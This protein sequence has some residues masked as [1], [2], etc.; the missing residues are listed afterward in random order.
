[1]TN[2]D[3]LK[4]ADEIYPQAV[5]IRRYLHENP[6]IGNKE[7]LA[8][9]YIK[10]FLADCGIEVFS[11]L[12]TG[13]VGVLSCGEG[14][15]V[16]L[17]ADID[18]LP[19]KEETALPYSSKN[20]GFMH[21]CGHDLHTAALLAAA[22]VLSQHKD[23][24]HGT[25][26]FIFQ[27]DEEGFGGA[28]R[29]LAAGAF[30]NPD[31]S[32]VFGI[33]IRPEIQSGTVAVRYGKSYAASDIFT[34]TVKGKSAHG[35]EPQNGKN[36]LIAA[37]NICK[38]LENIIAE[39]LGE[40][41]DA[42]LSICTFESGTACNIIPDKATVTG[43]IRTFGKTAR[44]AVKE[45]LKKR[46]ENAAR[47]NGCEADIHIRESYPGVVN[48]NEQTDFVLAC[49]NELFGKENTLV[50]SHP[51]LT[52]EDFG[53]YLDEADGCFYHIGAGSEYPLHNGKM[54]PDEH[55][56]KAAVAMHIKTVFEALKA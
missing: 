51:T 43:I 38:A 34:V 13:A 50:L 16:A 23:E 18:A 30:Q 37:A 5:A 52:T 31:V 33:H 45:E 12:E 41:D 26:K 48:N 1:M 8:T 29:M 21:A 4:F 36:A 42:V 32:R 35:A 6:E 55:C 2:Q 7:F 19:I 3:I 15:C 53:Y 24:L 11:P 49:A 39:T 44:T 9:A 28:D 46:A 54:A 40:E 25:V 20:E 17:R 27:P 56:L 14:A 47:I 22:K 10:S